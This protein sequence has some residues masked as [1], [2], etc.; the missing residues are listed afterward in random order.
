[1]I[2]ADEIKQQALKWW[3]PFLQSCLIKE[4]F[5]PKKIERIGKVK[6]SQII[7][8]FEAIQSEIESLYKT[9]KNN[10]GAGYLIKTS[11]RNYRRTG[12]HELP[13]TIEFES[14]ADYLHFTGKK[15]EWQL[16]MRHSQEATDNL[17]EMKEWLYYNVEM[18]TLPGI[19]WA[20]IIKVCRY[21]IS[22]PRPGLYLRQIPVQVHTKF[23]EENDRLL[24]SLLDFLIPE[25]VRNHEQKK[26]SERYFLNN[27]E[28]LIR[29]R[30]LD[31][32]FLF[33]HSIAD[34]SIRLS[35]FQRMEWGCTN[36]LITENKMNFLTLP[37]IPSGMAIWSGG[38]FNVSYLKNAGWLTSKN[39]VYWGD[40]DEHGFQILHQIRSY[41]PQT[42]SIM[43]NRQTF[44]DFQD[45]AVTGERNKAETLHGLNDDEAAL[46]KFLKTLQTGNRLEQEKIPQSYADQEL[47]KILDHMP[48]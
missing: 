27:D 36:V 16:F 29:I 30:I 10:T 13:D 9:S 40:I 11:G 33:H 24:Q 15:K 43:M 48:G 20:D 2:N 35:D 38:G 3:R 32:N 5:F 22:T 14:A 8:R 47:H 41:Y 1:M 18:L 23:I 42:R 21:F 12:S 44:E 17:P 28:P 37:P 25:H 31:R 7:H 34:V 4:P 6:S 26:F 45:F 46:Y 19:N 39:I